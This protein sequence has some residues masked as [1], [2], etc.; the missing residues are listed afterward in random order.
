MLGSHMRIVRAQR[1]LSL[2]ELAGR[3][4]VSPATLSQVEN[5]KTRLSVTRLSEIA[6]V[7]D[8]PVAELLSTTPV[9]EEQHP[10]TGRTVEGKSRLRHTT[11]QTSAAT[12]STIPHAQ[13]WREY[14]ALDF[15]PVLESALQAFLETGYHGA[16]V[17]D[18]ARRCSLSVPG[19]Y[20]H[21]PSKQE[22]LRKILELTM[23]DLLTRARAAQQQGDEPVERVCLLVE[24]LA[25]FHTHRQDLAF[26]GAS[27]MR[28]L[29]PNNYR[30]IAN[31]RQD[32]QHMVDQEVEAAA[33][34]GKVKVQR[35][36]EASRAIV[37]M[38]TALAQW[39]RHN[40]TQP[41]EDIA[42]QYVQYALNL[43]DHRAT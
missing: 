22:L 25:L 41:P 15:D 5:G 27:E 38:C 34:Q 40:G 21:Y 23:T 30:Q 3:L 26:V 39:F 11:S 32:Q 10:V 42:E 1:G 36:R 12:A 29:Q 19:I 13:H 9:S 37:T 17:R 18:I 33:A 31:M 24:N 35:P 8:T 6:E 2:R 43:L 7:L 4:D 28:S 14:P 16:T 20:H